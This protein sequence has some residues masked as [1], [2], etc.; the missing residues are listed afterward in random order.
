MLYYLTLP[1]IYLLSVLPFRLLYLISDFFFFLIFR[2]VGYRKEVVYTNLRNSF[3]HYTEKEIER[4]AE[5]FY[6]YLCDMTL[7]TFKSLTISEAAMIR[8]CPMSQETKDLFG[9]LAREKQSVVLVLGHYGNWEWAG[10]VFSLEC[11]QQLF[12]IYHPLTSKHFDGLMRRMRTRF[13]TRLIPMKTVFRDMLANREMTSATA[14]IADQT[15]TPANA[16]WMRFLNQDT[17]VFKGTEVIAKKLGFP[18][19]YMGVYRQSRGYYEI[20]GEMLCEQPAFEED[21]VITQKHVQRLEADIVAVPETWL[22]SHRRWKH[23]REHKG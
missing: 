23:K 6:H 22:W 12:V 14:F 5:K 19:V 10:N 18:I 3:P 4:T 11:D 9:R 8:H 2:V 17:P 7:E 1:F 16:M 13:G 20:R 21:G 15:P